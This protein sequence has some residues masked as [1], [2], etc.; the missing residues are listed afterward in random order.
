[1]LKRILAVTFALLFGAVG[2]AG[3]A[4]ADSG[5]ITN[6][7]SGLK[8]EDLK[9]GDGVIATADRQVAVHYTGWL[10]DGTKFD[11]S[12]DR[13]KPFIFTLGAG[14]VI[15]GWDE[16]VEGMKV[17]GVR[18]LTVPSHLGYGERG[19]GGAI[20]PNATLIFEVMLLGVK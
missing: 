3:M 19:T 1:M 4:S 7:P 2:F 15:K 5:H 16:G 10:E 11:S 20:P 18:R 12:L 8:Y 9:D 13:G 6:T 14:R 17:G